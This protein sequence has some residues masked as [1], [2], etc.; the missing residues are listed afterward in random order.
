MADEPSSTS[1]DPQITFTVKS[2]SDSKYTITVPASTTVA[3]LKSKL[4]SGD[5]ADIPPARQ[6]LIYSGRVLK[7]PDTLA[8]YKVKDGHT[9]HLVKGA[10]SN[11]RQ[12][13]ANQGGGAAAAGLGGAQGAGTGAA[14]NVPS[15]IAAGTGS[16]NI[17]AG[18]TGARFAG[19]AQLPGMEMFGADGGMGAPPDM[20]AML[21]MLENPQT[22]T[23]MAEALNNPDVLNMIRNSPMARQNPMMQQ[24]LNDPN[25]R[26]MMFNPEMLRMQMQ[27]QRQMRGMGGAGAANAFPAPGVTDTTPADAQGQDR[28]QNQQQQQQQQQAN[29]FAMFGGNPGAGSGANPFAALFGGNPGAAQ[30]T[31]PSAT[32][33]PPPPNPTAGQAAGTDAANP[34]ANIFGPPPAGQGAGGGAANDPMMEMTRQ[35]MQNPEMMRSAMQMLGG[36]TSNPNPNPNQNQNPN[37]FN[38]LFNPASLF[39][40]ATQ[41]PPPPPVDTRAPEERYAEQLRQLNDMGFYD[42]ERNVTALRRAGGSVAGAVEM[43]LEGV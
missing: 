3:E 37:P 42:F 38:T 43:L 27:M 15:N 14:S 16:N 36:D 18:L 28:A 2:S 35:M 17:L 9:I 13:P 8:S 26:R 23:M 24:V 31:T 7:D 32:P 39:G 33:P 41:Q 1:E 20:D 4:E 34:F 21:N 19:H 5:Y 10:E 6:R 29:P 40:A 12:S 25:L 30:G 22:A 11:Q